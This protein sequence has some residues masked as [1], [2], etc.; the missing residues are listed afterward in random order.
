VSKSTIDDNEK[1]MHEIER[2]II[3]EDK[4]LTEII[5]NC[6]ILFI[7]KNNF[8]RIDPKC[9]LD[10]LDMAELMYNSVIFTCP[11]QF[12]D[13]LNNISNYQVQILLYAIKF[14]LNC[15]YL[16]IKV[17]RSQKDYW[18]LIPKNIKIN[19]AFFSG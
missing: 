16:Y 2:I 3:N 9:R 1:K 7:N 8:H 10:P 13:A 19:Y 18:K 14:V 11:K 4:G 15:E 6:K 12:F 5:K 17:D